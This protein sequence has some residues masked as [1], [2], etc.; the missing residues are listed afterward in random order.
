MKKLSI[1]LVIILLLQSGVLAKDYA[2]QHL[3]EMQKN[4]KYTTSDKFFANKNLSDEN[5]TVLSEI[6]D[7]KIFKVYNFKK[8]DDNKYKEKLKSD[9]AEYL[10][11]KKQFSQ[12]TLDAIIAQQVNGEDCYRIY[13]IVERIIRANNLDF[14]NWRI[15][16]I[17]DTSF[18]ASSSEM[19]CITIN[20]A[21]FDTFIDN[22]DAFAF[23]IGHEMAHSL[24]GHSERKAKL[25]NKIERAYRL[26]YTYG[27]ALAY[28]IDIS[29]FLKQSRNMEYA[30]D[31]EGA[32]LVAKAGY[33]LNKA[34]EAI[35]FMC[36]LPTGIER[37]STHPTGMHRLENFNDNRKYFTEDEWKDYGRFNIY[38][39]QVLSVRGSSDRKTIII[40]KGTNPLGNQVNRIENIA[41]IY[42]RYGYKSYING[43]FQAALKYFNKMFDVD[44]TNASAYLY[45]SYAS[46]ALYRKTGNSSYLDKAKEYVNNAKKIDNNK[47]IKEQV[48]NL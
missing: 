15:V 43:D 42:G 8:I 12:K 47:Y 31:N 20:T 19:N 33:D 45:A 10:K 39:S 48:E 14:I 26:R 34:S 46:E 37:Y 29:R 36:T 40:G 41:Q 6:K 3:K 11:Y 7:P 2:K 32:I 1:L 38:N 25:L 28:R 27:G 16:I 44:K 5:S 13:R 22:E 17:R 30:A 21:L 4:Q 23:I 18:N 9:E 24:L 35:S